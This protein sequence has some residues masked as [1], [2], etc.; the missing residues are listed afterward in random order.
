MSPTEPEQ[1]TL[2]TIGKAFLLIVAVI[3]AVPKFVRAVVKVCQ[4][5]VAFARLI[6]HLEGL[7]AYMRDMKAWTI[8]H[9]AS[10]DEANAK[11]LAALMARDLVLA[12]IRDATT[13]VTK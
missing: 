6:P 10:D 2:T 5:V 8:A 13:K 1:N 11:T 7:P 4:A 9:Q 12:E 3:Y